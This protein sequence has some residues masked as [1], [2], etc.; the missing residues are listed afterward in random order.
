MKAGKLHDVTVKVEMV[1]EQY[2]SNEMLEKM[3]C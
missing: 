3:E 1:V 2:E